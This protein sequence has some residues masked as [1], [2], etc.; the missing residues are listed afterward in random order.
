MN[1]RTF[2]KGA[3]ALPIALSLP[4]S[5]MPANIVHAAPIVN[6]DNRM[7]DIVGSHISKELNKNLHN[8]FRGPIVT[9]HKWTKEI[10]PRNR[11]LDISLL[12]YSRERTLPPEGLIS[13]IADP[14]VH[15]FIEMILKHN[16]KFRTARFAECEDNRP[17]G[18]YEDGS[19]SVRAVEGYDMNY[20]TSILSVDIY[21]IGV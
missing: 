10:P 17:Y 3:A 13:E 6:A 20:M 1:R 2:L 12:V 16:R 19:V 7:L 4:L 21:L 18:R 14:M 8:V 9:N 11:H 5:S 15:R